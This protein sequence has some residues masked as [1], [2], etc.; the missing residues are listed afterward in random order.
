MITI[1]LAILAVLVLVLLEGFFSGS[2]TV[3]TSANKAVL[4]EKAAKGDQRARRVV[5]MLSCSE[6]FLGTTLTG[7]NL[8]GVCSTT[9]C[10]IFIATTLLRSGVVERALAQCDLQLSWENVLT[11]VMM[12]PLIL[13]FGELIPKSIGRAQC[14]TLALT[15]AY[16]MSIA[17]RVMRPLVVVSGWA[18]GLLARLIGGGAANPVGY[19]TREDLRAITELAAEQGVVPETA[20]SMLKTVFDLEDRSVESMMVPLVDVLSV[21]LDATVA[22]VE[23]LSVE[24]GHARFPVYGDRFD[25]IM[26]IV[27]CRQLLYSAAASELFSA[28]TLIAPHVHR[29]VIF[30][31]DSKPVG[32]L[33]H[34]LRYQKMPMAV[35]VDEHG[36][37]VG[38]LTTEDLIEEIVGDINDERDAPV[39]EVVHLGEKLLEC[40]GRLDV[41]DLVEH[42]GVEIELNGFD[43][44]AGLVLKLAG[45]IPEVGDVFECRGYEVTVLAMERRRVKR[46]RFQ[47]LA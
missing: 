22:D 8:A 4:R 31:P 28:E 39:T 14:D 17:E 27:D 46:L 45:R 41:R 33:L 34:E 13:M 40:D 11:T 9:I 15:L 19:V 44:A 23:R 26:G 38:I 35:V 1:L 29:N 12:T 5:E 21:P 42:L 43:T 24:T 6:R 18:S 30:A 10:Q 37:V 47:R 7:T 32:D 25:D 16:P 3:Y 36:V 20:G 2:E